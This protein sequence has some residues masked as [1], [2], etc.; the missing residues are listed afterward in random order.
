MPILAPLSGNVPETTVHSLP[1]SIEM[2]SSLPPRAAVDMYFKPSPVSPEN[3]SNGATDLVGAQFRGRGLVGRVRKV[4][5]GCIGVTLAP[6]SALPHHLQKSSDETTCIGIDGQFTE[7]TVW[8]HDFAP[9]LSGNV[10]TIAEEW[11][12]LARAIHGEEDE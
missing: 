4:P 3:A 9:T 12:E 10:V 5:E 2:N 8:G 6:V 1:C 7:M 11:I